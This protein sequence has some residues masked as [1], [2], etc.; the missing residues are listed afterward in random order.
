MQEPYGFLDFKSQ[1]EKKI[2]MSFEQIDG[3][4]REKIKFK[5]KFKMFHAFEKKVID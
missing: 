2:G 1:R 3:E 4:Q 5:K